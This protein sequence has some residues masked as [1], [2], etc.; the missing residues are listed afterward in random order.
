MP[1]VGSGGIGAVSW[2]ISASLV[3][4]LILAV[5][6]FVAWKAAKFLWIAFLK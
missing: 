4:V 2:G 3:G 1:E 6:V 5:V